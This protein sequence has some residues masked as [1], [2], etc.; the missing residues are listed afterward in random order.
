MSITSIWNVYEILDNKCYCPCCPFEW[1]DYILWAKEPYQQPNT[2]PY[3]ESLNVK[4]PP[5][6]TSWSAS[7]SHMNIE[8][9]DLSDHYP[10]LAKFEFAVEDKNTIHLDGCTEDSDCTFYAFECF[11]TGPHC[12]YNGSIVNGRTYPYDHPVNKNCLYVK[13]H[14]DCICGPS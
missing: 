5:F 4:V 8:L 13:T 2:V 12:Y 11:C 14:V 7:E 6:V 9:A 3:V 1:L 10:V